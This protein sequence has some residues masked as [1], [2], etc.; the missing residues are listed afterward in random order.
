[1]IVILVAGVVVV[2]VSFRSKTA[3]VAVEASA[4][5]VVSTQSG[6]GTSTQEGRQ[7]RG[8]SSL[9]IDKTIIISTI[10]SSILRN[11]DNS[12]TGNTVDLKLQVKCPRPTW[13]PKVSETEGRDFWCEFVTRIRVQHR[14]NVRTMQR[15]AIY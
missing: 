12:P 10:L 2:L 4:R 14:Q 15:Q 9:I 11:R 7:G 1:V 13:G 8:S 6:C 5:I 3:M